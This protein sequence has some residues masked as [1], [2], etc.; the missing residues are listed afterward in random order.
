MQTGRLREGAQKK[1]V[2]S[3]QGPAR[4]CI[5][6]GS[7]PRT[8]RSMRTFFGNGFQCLA[9]ADAC[10][11]TIEDEYLVAFRQR[12][13]PRGRVGPSHRCGHSPAAAAEPGWCRAPRAGPAGSTPTRRGCRRRPPRCRSLVSGSIPSLLSAGTTRKH[14]WRLVPKRS[15]WAIAF[16][17][18][19][20][21]VPRQ[22]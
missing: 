10:A 13:S 18:P 19:K 9:G 21:R 7:R 2:L 3:P 15:S 22:R 11:G 16:S 4:D 17:A 8:Y 5:A 6:T 20:S 14:R 12:L 1:D